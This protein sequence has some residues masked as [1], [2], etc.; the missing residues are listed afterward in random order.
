MYGNTPFFQHLRAFY[1]RHTNSAWR[2]ILGEMPR[3][4]L[5]NQLCAI[6]IIL[7]VRP[8]GSVFENIVFSNL[9]GF[10]CYVLIRTGRHL[11]WP[12]KEPG[13]LAFYLLC[14]V[15]SPFGFIAGVAISATIFS[16]PLEEVFS[17]QGNYVITFVSMTC[18]IST[19]VAWLFW[20]R[21]KINALHAQAEAEK[22]RYALIERQA[23][24][25]QLQLLQAQIEPH[26]LFN[27]LANLQGLIAIDATRAQHMLTQLIV[28][29]RATLCAS[30]A[31][32]TTLGQEFTLIR[33]YLD[34]LAI[35][36][37]SRLSYTLDLPPDL[38][39]FPLPPMLL[40]PLVEN[41]IR[42]GLEPKIEGGHILVQA[43]KT[44]GFLRLKIADTGLGLPF[45]YDEQPA[46]SA[47]GH[48]VGNANIRERLQAIFGAS[49]S[50]TLTPNHP[51]GVIAEL[52]IPYSGYP[53]PTFH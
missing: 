46:P 25:T 24:Q 19:I 31:E 33:A 15:V 17:L 1:L 45:G 27:T 22:T 3:L 30:R 52:T 23:M 47:D 6:V 4:L 44:T 50:L 35:R 7:L 8:D 5:I 11:I 43:S 34:L 18:I 48:H 10:C 16:Y 51:E 42:H 38:A 36:M 39:A 20:N 28:Y 9:I 2:T 21:A 29:L 12:D 26:M 13:M 49:A 41:A 40:Q 53:D 32:T 14:I 37:G